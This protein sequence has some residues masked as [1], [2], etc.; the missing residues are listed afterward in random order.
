MI[1][2][3]TPA[4]YLDALS[5]EAGKA[6]FAAIVVGCERETRFVW[7]TSDDAAAQLEGLLRA[8]GKAVAI[9]GADIA[10]HAFT[11]RLNPFPEDED[12]AGT[13]RYLAAV[14]ENVAGIL[15]QRLQAALN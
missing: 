4:D 3:R 13:R 7:S 8:G 2:S 1:P 15:E 12:D 9:L 14:G 5:G 6:D 10:V 11:Y